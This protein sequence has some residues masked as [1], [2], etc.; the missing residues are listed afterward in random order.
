[1]APAPPETRTRLPWSFTALGLA[2][3]IAHC[4]ESVFQGLGRILRHDAPAVRQDRAFL[5][6]APDFFP[7]QFFE[8]IVVRQ[9]QDRVGLLD[10]FGKRLDPLGAEN[11]RGDGVVGRYFRAADAQVTA[12]NRGLATYIGNLGTP[13]YQCVPPTGWSD[14]GSDWVNPSSQLYRMNFA[15]DLAG[16]TVS[17]VTVDARAAAAGADFSSPRSVASVL[18]ARVFGGTLS[19]GTLDAVARLDTRSSVSVASRALTLTLCSPEFQEK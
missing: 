16:G 3:P 1:M 10:A 9:D 14:R 17:G 4:D 2:C 11:V 8:F 19:P 15:I 7:V 5:E 18:N 12:A 6:L 13:L